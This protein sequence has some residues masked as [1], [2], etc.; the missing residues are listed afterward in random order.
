MLLIVVTVFTFCWLPYETYLVLNEVC[1]AI[2]EYVGC[3][4]NKK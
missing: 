3:M 1:S 2:N 4:E